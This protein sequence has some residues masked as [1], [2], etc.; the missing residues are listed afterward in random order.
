MD[1]S[2]GNRLRKPTKN[3]LLASSNVDVGLFT[4]YRKLKIRKQYGGAPYMA[5]CALVY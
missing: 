4:L 1:T 5:D 2:S 3:V